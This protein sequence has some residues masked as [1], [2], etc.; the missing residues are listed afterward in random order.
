MVNVVDPV[1]PLEAAWMVVLPADAAVASP[2]AAIVATDVFDEVHAAVLV[3]SRVE[4]SL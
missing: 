3:R 2:P 4:L 1:I